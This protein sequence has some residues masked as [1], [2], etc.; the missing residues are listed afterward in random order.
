MKTRLPEVSKKSNALETKWWLRGIGELQTVPRQ[1]Q[2]APM[3]WKRMLASQGQ[4]IRT[5]WK[6]GGCRETMS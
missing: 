3:S 5:R 1:C 6:P 4:E 2:I